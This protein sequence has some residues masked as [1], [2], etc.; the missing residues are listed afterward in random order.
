MG[1]QA[2]ERYLEAQ[3]GETAEILLETAGMGRTPQFAEV[4]LAGAVD[5]GRGIVSARLNR[6]AGTHLE[7]EVVA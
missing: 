3:V 4:R 1:S 7:G 6:R 2:L 5:P